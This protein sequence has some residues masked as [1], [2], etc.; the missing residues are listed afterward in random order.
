M[1]LGADDT[2]DDRVVDV[3]RTGQTAAACQRVVPRAPV[4]V[5]SSVGNV[6][7]LSVQTHVLAGR[8]V[9]IIS[10]HE[11]PV[12]LGRPARGTGAG[13]GYHDGGG[14]EGPAH[15]AGDVLVVVSVD[16][17]VFRSV[18]V[19]RVCRFRLFVQLRRHGETKSVGCS[20]CVTEPRAPCHS[21]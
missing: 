18:Q 15:G 10:R 4:L 12:V 21:C 17:L 11:V 13:G 7:R 16:G 8:T 1:L 19:A 3:G 2:R 5:L 20:S 14:L 9:E 6:F